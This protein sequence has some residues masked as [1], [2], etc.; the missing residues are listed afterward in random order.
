MGRGRM[1]KL[2]RGLFGVG[3]VGGVVLTDGRRYLKSKW[4]WYGV[5]ALLLIFLPNLIWQTQHHFVSLDFLRHIHERDIR[6]GRTQGFLPDQLKLTLLAFPLCVAGL[7]FYLFSR[8]GRRFR[9]LGLMCV[10]PPL[11]V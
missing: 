3:I 1:T 10:V 9:V 11:L 8:G 6:I 4:L 2:T 7:Y 5:A